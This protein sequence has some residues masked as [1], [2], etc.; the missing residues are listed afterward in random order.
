VK[1]LADRQKI[2]PALLKSAGVIVKRKNDGIRFIFKRTQVLDDLKQ[3]GFS[4]DILKVG[5]GEISLPDLS[6]HVDNQAALEAYWGSLAEKARYEFH[7]EEDE[8]NLWHESKYSRC[9]GELQDMGIPKPTQKEVEARISS[10]Y[11][12]HLSK[13]KE[14]L[15]KLE[16][17][18]RIMLNVC[19]ASVV[20]KGRMLQSLR[21][22][23]QGG[24]M[25]IPLIE[26]ERPPVQEVNCLKVTRE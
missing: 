8:Y 13:R 11:Q 26:T 20:T 15:R 25:K 14:K 1:D 5:G 16:S 10:K 12:K 22:I 24:N 17:N 2:A 21:N 6:I 19:Y 18:Y 23:I 4:L 9:F 7:A 3:I